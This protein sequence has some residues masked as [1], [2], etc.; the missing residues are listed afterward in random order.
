MLVAS[1]ISNLGKTAQSILSNPSSLSAARA[2]RQ[3]TK[4]EEKQAKDAV[5]AN[6]ASEPTPREGLGAASPINSGK[7]SHQSAFGYNSNPRAKSNKRKVQFKDVYDQRSITDVKKERSSRERDLQSF[8]KQRTESLSA[9][10]SDGRNRKA[11]KNKRSAEMASPYFTN[12]RGAAKAAGADEAL[13]YEVQNEDNAAANFNISGYALSPKSSVFQPI[14][15]GSVEEN[16]DNMDHFR[17]PTETT[18]E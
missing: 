11:S 18:E 13:K 5:E 3:M 8:T 10:R 6:S 12:S 14:V 2:G 1:D 9:S 7:Q 4:E 15:D 16:L 17:L